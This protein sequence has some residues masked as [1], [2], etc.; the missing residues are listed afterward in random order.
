MVDSSG[1]QDNKDKPL[2]IDCE[3][4]GLETDWWTTIHTKQ[5]DEY[6]DEKEVQIKVCWNCDFDV[7]NGCDVQEDPSD[8]IADRI[9]L[10]HEYDPINNPRLC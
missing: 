7:M 10:Q 5:E 6:G 9:E 1:N 2:T 3:R 8:I 4:C